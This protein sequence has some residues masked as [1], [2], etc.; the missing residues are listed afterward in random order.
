[1]AKCIR[2]NIYRDKVCQWLTIGLWVS[3]VSSTNKT[4]ILDTLASGQI[5]TRTLRHLCETFRCQDKLA[6]RQF[7]TSKRQIGTCVFF[8]D[9][10]YKT[11]ES[12]ITLN[13][14]KLS[15]KK[16]GEIL[17]FSNTNS[18]NIHRRLCRVKNLLA[19]YRKYKFLWF[20]LKKKKLITFVWKKMRCRFVL[21]P[22]CLFQ[23]VPKCIGA[24]LSCY[25]KTDR[26][27][28]IEI[29]L[30]MASNSI[31]LTHKIISNYTYMRFKIITQW[32]KSTP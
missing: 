26:L 21:I 7:G 23:W 10:T 17:C 25:N 11:H 8:F 9:F 14:S 24:E 4:G 28:K 12:W 20:Y 15:L 13:I 3:P 6:P 22:N 18:M 2:Y 32:R 16:N 31:T 1:M 27:D 5:G 30:K 19:M 29:L